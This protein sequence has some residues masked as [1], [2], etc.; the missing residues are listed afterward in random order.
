[1][2]KSNPK[3]SNSGKGIKRHTGGKQI[4]DEQTDADFVDMDLDGLHNDE[5]KQKKDH[6][7]RGSKRGNKTNKNSPFKSS[8]RKKSKQVDESDEEVEFLERR[9]NSNPNTIKA[10]FQ[11]DE[12]E[13]TFEVQ[14]H[15]GD[16][17]SEV[18]GTEDGEILGEAENGN[19]ETASESEQEE[20][21]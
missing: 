6:A 11:E 20:D 1:M 13:V 8:K 18:E 17:D 16:F 10:V 21:S 3:N 14:G 9:E 4:C 15:I 2:P 12:D 19:E 7:Q 5:S